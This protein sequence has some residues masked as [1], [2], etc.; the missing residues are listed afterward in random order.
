MALEGRHRDTE[1]ETREKP[2]RIAAASLP[3]LTPARQVGP[4]QI[5]AALL[6][7]RANRRDVQVERNGPAPRVVTVPQQTSERRRA[8]AGRSKRGPILREDGGWKSET[9]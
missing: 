5:D 6:H 9:W 2:V 4:V 1:I 7:Q 8:R 3:V